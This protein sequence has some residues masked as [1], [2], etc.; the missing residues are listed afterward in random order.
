M[1]KIYYTCDFSYILLQS[2]SKKLLSAKFTQFKQED[3]PCELLIEACKQLDLYFSGN[4]KQFDLP[5]AILGTSF[6]RRVYEALCEIPYSQTVSYKELAAS[7]GAKNAARAVGRANAKNALPIFVPCHRVVSSKGL[8]G[9]SAG[10][11]LFNDIR[12][13]FEKIQAFNKI[14]K[15]CKK[16]EF[17]KDEFIKPSVKELKKQTF[18]KLKTN[19]KECLNLNT[20]E[21]EF[22]LKFNSSL[23][24]KR[25]LL[26]L[27]GV[28][29]NYL[30]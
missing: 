25:Y 9:Y 13:D 30:D 15:A 21:A 23:D 7:I 26:R 10:A 11:E 18:N 29:R 22:K 8:G 20:K 6:E 2:D 16:G 17:I 4:L 12:Q 14:S 27:E 24:I 19:L 28:K 1:F 3:H 5:L